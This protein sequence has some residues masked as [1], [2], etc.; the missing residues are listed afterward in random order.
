MKLTAGLIF[1]GVMANKG[2]KNWLWVHHVMGG[3]GGQ[4]DDD[5]IYFPQSGLPRMTP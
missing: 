2:P 1:A 5:L 3:S 4:P